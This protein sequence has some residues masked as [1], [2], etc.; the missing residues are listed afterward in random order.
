[1]NAAATALAPTTSAHPSRVLAVFRLHFVNPVTVAWMPL[2]I[3]GF[4]FAMN[5]LIWLIVNVSTS[6]GREGMAEGTT[7][8]GAS[9]FIFVWLLVIAVQAMNRTFH[10]ALGFG[11]TRRDYYLGTLAALVLSAAGWSIVFG[12]LAVIEEATDGWGLGGHMFASVYFG[13]DGPIARVWYV[14]LL[15]LFFTAIGLV[16]GALF[17]RWRTFGLIGFFAVLA[18]VLVGGLAWIGLT[19]SW[20]AVGSFFGTLGFAG[21]YP[22]FL[23]PIAIAVALG[24]LALRRATAR[25]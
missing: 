24:Y 13:D 1:M 25:S 23:V 2:G 17:V 11:A 14:F 9:M 3:Y 18:L 21:G 8:S 16:A 5:W 7:W 15:M 20:A 4:I 22:L 19:N 6:D 12:I 10:F